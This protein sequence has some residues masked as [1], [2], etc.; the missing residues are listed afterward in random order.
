MKYQRMQI[1]R[2]ESLNLGGLHFVEITTDT[3]LSGLGQSACW[4]Y[5]MAV[6]AIIAAFRGYLLGQDPRR[7][8]HHWQHLY[9]MGP[10]R[11]SVLGA[12]LSAVDIALWDIKG[13]FHQAPIWDLLGGSC[14]N[15]I[16]LHLLIL[17]D[18]G[19]EAIAAK[20]AEGMNQGFTAVKFDP[21][22][23]SA[24]DM[25]L[26]QLVHEVTERVAAAREAAGRN[27]DL[28]LE[29]HRRLTPLQALPVIEA[30]NRFHPLFTEDPIQIDSIVS[31]ADLARRI[32]APIGNGE[33]LN[34]IW[35][36]RE[37]LAHGGTQYLRPDLGLAGGIT[38]CK[39]IAAIAESYHAAIVSHNFLGPVLTAASAHLD[40]AIPNFV[41]QEYSMIDEGPSAA[42][43]TSSLQR[44]GGYLLLPEQ[45]GLGVR[46]DRHT[47]LW[48]SPYLTPLHET[49]LRADGS[50]AYSV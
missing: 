42:A 2:V 23:V 46:V 26:A 4:A 22:P 36:F 14:R 6:D 15:R 37:L 32:T 11:G 21:I 43:Y 33:R 34:T 35:E 25:A 29:F 18:F 49:P 27:V 48:L 5:P 30:V 7:I 47:D 19:P 20:V 24:G 50:V 28:I 45:P 41:V 9:R 10:F 12:A 38:H 17:G 39:K 8:E 44:E 16:R 3:G 31:Q 13:Q 1:E 40:A